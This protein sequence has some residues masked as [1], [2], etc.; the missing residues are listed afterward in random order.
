MFKRQVHEQ[1]LAALL[2]E[3]IDDAVDR[4]VRAVG[5]QR[6]EHQVPRLGE[7]NSVFHGLAVADFAD[8][9]HVG[10]LAQ[11]VLERE[12]PAVAIDADFPVRDHA[13][14]VRVHVL[15]RV[16]DGDD[17]SAGLLVPVADHG[18]ERGGFARTG[19]AH[20]DHEAAL[21]QHDVLQHGGSSSSSKSGSWR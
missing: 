13:A 1:L 3:E 2:G 9:D 7:L 6:G 10:R 18:R 11:R 20:Q 15:H 17:V 19:A 8:Q 14:L 21:G 5:V 16:L 4:L 12:M